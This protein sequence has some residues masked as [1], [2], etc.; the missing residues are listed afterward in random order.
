MKEKTEFKK[1]K[2]NQESGSRKVRINMKVKNVEKADK[3][4][5]E[6]MD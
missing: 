6:K 2:N 4:S 5:N 1:T 3:K